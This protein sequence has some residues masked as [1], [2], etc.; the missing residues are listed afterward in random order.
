MKGVIFVKIE[1]FD[2]KIS[3]FRSDLLNYCD[4]NLESHCV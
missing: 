1:E 3:K 2:V 4:F